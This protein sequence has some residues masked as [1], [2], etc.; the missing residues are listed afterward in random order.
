M[1][2][3]P[4]S[5]IAFRVPFL[6]RSELLVSICVVTFSFLLCLI[7]MPQFRVNIDE[8]IKSR[9][10]RAQNAGADWRGRQGDIHQSSICDLRGCWSWHSRHQSDM[11]WHLQATINT[12][13]SSRL[14]LVPEGIWKRRRRYSASSCSAADC[15]WQ[16]EHRP[17]SML[18]GRH[19]VHIHRSV[20]IATARLRHSVT[21]TWFIHPF[22][23]SQ[24]EPYKHADNDVNACI[25]TIFLN[26]SHYFLHV[27]FAVH[28]CSVKCLGWYILGD[29]EVTSLVASELFK[30]TSLFFLE[31]Q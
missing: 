26:S 29:S 20:M 12:P 17:A 10:Y 6:H 27:M 23:H 22:I 16:P 28:L 11:G 7:V 18:T 9:A 5:V 4:K 8:V 3:G 2:Y 21:S 19:P 15:C 1:R 30:F 14:Q 25:L 13:T 24:L 31:L